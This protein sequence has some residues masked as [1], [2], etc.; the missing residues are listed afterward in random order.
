MALSPGHCRDCERVLL[1]GQWPK[2]PCCP[3]LAS[4]GLPFP[5]WRSVHLCEVERTAPTFSSVVRTTQGASPKTASQ[6]MRFYPNVGVL[7]IPLCTS[8]LRN[9]LGLQQ[10]DPFLTSHSRFRAP[11]CAHWSCLEAQAPTHSLVLWCQPPLL[12]GDVTTKPEL[13]KHESHRA[14]RESLELHTSGLPHLFLSACP[15]SLQ[16]RTLES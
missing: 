4:P 9:C 13:Q 12:A 11:P 1:P 3:G 2:A 8:T 16:T 7:Q 10:P 6:T 15:Q 14:L 5:M